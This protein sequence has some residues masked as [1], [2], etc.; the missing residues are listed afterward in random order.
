MRKGKRFSIWNKEKR[1]GLRQAKSLATWGECVSARFKLPKGLCVFSQFLSII[2]YTT[3]NFPPSGCPGSKNGKKQ[4]TL[5]NKK[6]R[7]LPLAII[8]F[9]PNWIKQYTTFT[10]SFLCQW[11]F[12]HE[13]HK[14]CIFDHISEWTRE[15]FSGLFQ[16]KFLAHSFVFQCTTKFANAALATIA[17]RKLCI[18]NGPSYYIKLLGSKSGSQQKKIKIKKQQNSESL[19]PQGQY[20]GGCQAPTSVKIELFDH[21]HGR[22][23][24]SF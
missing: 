15:R 6:K 20:D 14:K 24:I 8:S 9:D 11:P 2:K 5:V 13:K 21:F 17:L 23:H 22:F 18:Y 3:Y 12:W 16:I 10:F 7:I 4:K 19:K 1:E